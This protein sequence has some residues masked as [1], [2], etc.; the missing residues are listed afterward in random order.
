MPRLTVEHTQER[1]WEAE[2]HRL[3]GELLLAGGEPRGAED[4]YRRALDV[5]RGQ[6][7][8]ALELRAAISLARLWRADGRGDEARELL[9]R[10]YGWFTEGWDTPDL[11]AAAELLEQLGAPTHQANGLTLLSGGG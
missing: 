6:G 3:R 5:A 11:L 4:S 7:A 1:Y 10:V 8:H 9:V 2:I